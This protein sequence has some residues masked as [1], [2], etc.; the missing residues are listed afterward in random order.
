MKFD[1]PAFAS[2]HETYHFRSKDLSENC[3]GYTTQLADG[4]ETNPADLADALKICAQN[5]WCY[6]HVPPFPEGRG[7]DDSAKMLHL[8]GNVPPFPGDSTIKITPMPRDKIGIVFIQ[9]LNY[10]ILVF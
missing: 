1:A 7:R 6:N 9:I 2:F 8:F 4:F 5:D 10:L 3:S